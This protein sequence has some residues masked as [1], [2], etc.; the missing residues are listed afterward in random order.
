MQVV[1]YGAVRDALF[2]SWD[3]IG[4]SH[5][6][7]LHDEYD[8]YVPEIL[9]ML[10]SGA[11]SESIAERLADFE[12]K[13]FCETSQEHRRRAAAVLIGLCRGH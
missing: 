9:R 5:N 6:E 8:S 2:Y 12:R 10:N 7:N 13:L 1:T 3:P 11:S 4:V